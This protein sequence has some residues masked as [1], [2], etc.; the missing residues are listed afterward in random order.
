MRFLT[1]LYRPLDE[2]GNRVDA[3]RY[4]NALRTLAADLEKLL[5]AKTKLRNRLRERPVDRDQVVSDL[6]DIRDLVT[7]VSTQVEEMAA[8]L[9]ASFAEEGNKVANQLHE[10]A[11]AK[12]WIQI[13]QNNISTFSGE[14][15]RGYAERADQTIP[16]LR[17]TV[18]AASRLRTYVN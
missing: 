16:I 9:R 1:A 10:A 13:L 7:G 8:G 12:T 5:Q 17:D 11:A 18:E 4:R 3:I 2:L 14:Q 15:L 6:R